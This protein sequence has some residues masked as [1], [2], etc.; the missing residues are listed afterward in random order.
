M[1]VYQE[2]GFCLLPRRFLAQIEVCIVNTQPNLVARLG[3]VAIAKR[4]EGRE[5][6]GRRGWQMRDCETNLGDRH[7]ALWRQRDGERGEGRGGERERR[8]QGSSETV[9]CS[10]RGGG[11]REMV[12][13]WSEGGES[14]RQRGVV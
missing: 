9:R 10:E 1:A 2:G 4:L 11:S 12:G 3:D 6:E 8:A 13:R 14:E 5:E 7:C